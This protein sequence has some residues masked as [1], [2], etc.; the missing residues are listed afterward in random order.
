[1]S[2]AVLASRALVGLQAP[3]V[4]VEVHLANGL[5]AFTLVGLPDVEVREARDRVRAALQTGQLIGYQ[6]NLNASL[7]ETS[8]HSQRE[9]QSALHCNHLPGSKQ[10]LRTGS[11]TASKQLPKEEYLFAHYRRSQQLPHHFLKAQ[12]S[13]LQFSSIGGAPHQKS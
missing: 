9:R 1:M 12:R 4:C 2:L 7:M 8:A 13:C 5:P 3:E 11:E 6:Q 10:H